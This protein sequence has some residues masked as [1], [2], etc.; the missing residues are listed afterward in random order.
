ME[1]MM[2]VEYE[3]IYVALSYLESAEEKIRSA[4]YYLSSVREKLETAG[5]L[6]NDQLGKEGVQILIFSGGEIEAFESEIFESKG[7][8]SSEHI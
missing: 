6:S 3:N 8:C 7:T 2:V 1:V 4:K 5:V